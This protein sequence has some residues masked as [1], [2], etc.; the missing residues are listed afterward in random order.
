MTDAFSPRKA[1]SDSANKGSS[2]SPVRQ[3]AVFVM[4]P[5]YTGLGIARCLHSLGID[6][7]GLASE[8]DAPGVKSR[9]F[10]RIVE[11]P[12]GRSEPRQLCD[13]LLELGRALKHKPLLMPTRD[14]DVLFLH[15]NREALNTYYTLPQGDGSPI[16]RMM[17]KLEL[18]RVAESCGIPTPR[19]IVSDSL[20]DL[21]HKAVALRFPV[22]M[23]PRFAHK[24]RAEGVWNRVGAQKAIIVD[25]LQALTARYL[26]I[27]V[28]VSEV[29][30]Q[31]FIPGNDYDIVVCCGYI[32]EK[33]ELLGQFTA[34]KLQQ[35]PPLVG[36]G[37]AVEATELPS[38][39]DPT[40]ALLRTFH[41]VG[42]AEVEYKYDRAKDKYFL[43]EINPRHWDQHELGRLVGINLSAIAY[44]HLTGVA[45]APQAPSYQRNVHCRWIAER[46]LILGCLRRVN[47]DLRRPRLSTLQKLRNIRNT[48]SESF[49]LL[50]GRTVFSV[51]KLDDPHPAMRWSAGIAREVLSY[52]WSKLRSV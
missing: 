33:G 41:Y 21:H 51:I 42:M 9:F 31:E 37:C 50:S 36:T 24:W 46:E 34:R 8:R 43:I 27:S 40:R 29:L 18:A 12:D 1:S 7:V 39:I 38:I 52:M 11:V 26:D 28:A 15:E 6:V 44:R 10:Q 25:S 22:I 20:E 30:V 5:Y 23:K 35:D 19:T 2:E 32:D 49:S 47:A 16:M 4:N 14:F 3:P 48:L 17:D 45:Q 13:M